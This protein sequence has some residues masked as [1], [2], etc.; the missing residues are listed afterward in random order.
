MSFTNLKASNEHYITIVFS[1]FFII[2]VE[3]VSLNSAWNFVKKKSKT[4]QKKNY[5][6]S[7]IIL[8][9]FVQL[10]LFLVIKNIF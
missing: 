4:E 5:M 7:L 8:H 6:L 9:D 10:C 2:R 3:E 1:I